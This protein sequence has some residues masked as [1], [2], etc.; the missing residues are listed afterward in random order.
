MKPRYVIGIDPGTNTGIAVWDCEK[1]Q[2]KNVDSMKIHQAMD[3][4][5]YWMAYGSYDVLVR[6]EDARL[7]KWYGN[8]GN[9]AKQG[10]G[11]IKRDCAIWE[12]YLKDSGI[13]YQAVAP[14]NIKTKMTA[15]AFR[16][17]T[18]WKGRTNEHSRDSAMLVFGFVSGWAV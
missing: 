7:R 8:K 6:F 12:D 18:G 16:N 2:Y 14:K 10:A 9:E 4:V 1:K 5:E 3:E 15:E 17:L 11:S 13:E